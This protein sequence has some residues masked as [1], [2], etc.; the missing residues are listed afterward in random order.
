MKKTFLF[1]S[2]LTSI[3]LFS[4]NERPNILW[5][6]TE[7][8]SPDLSMYGD[9]LAK[10]PALDKLASESVIYDNVFSPVGVCAPTRSAIITGMYPTSIGTMHMRTGKDTGGWSKRVYDKNPKPQR[11]DINNNSVPQ[12]SAVIPAE[13]KCFTEYLRAIGYFCTNNSKTDYQFAA[14]ITSWD[15]NGGSAHWRNKQ[16]NQPFFSV[17]NFNVTH[18]SRLWMNAE[19]ELTVSPDSVKIPPYF[20]DTQTVRR[21]IARHYSNI[22]LMDKQVSGII[23]QLKEDGLY[24]N[25]IIFFYSDHGGP[26]PREKRAIYDSGLKVPMFIKDIDSKTIG[27]SDDLISFVDLAPT[28]LSLAN[29]EPPKYLDG[30]PFMGAFK[31]ELNEYVFGSSDRFD[32]FTDR[33]RSIRTKDF[34][35]VKNYF[36][37]KIKYKDVGYRKQI[38]MMVEFLESKEKGVLND[39]Q[40]IW[41][42]AKS[43]EE[44]Y[45]VKKDPYQMNNLIEDAEYQKQLKELR[46]VYD[47]HLKKHEDYG[48]TPELEMLYSMWPNLEQ[49]TTAM[50]KVKQDG[51]AVRISCETKG[52]SLAYIISDSLMENYDYDSKWQL[53]SEPLKSMNGKY[54]YI[55]A[56]RIGYKESEIVMHK[57]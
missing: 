21:D 51:K 24:D 32:E 23:E 7:D 35:Y 56:E 16:N 6:V 25:T 42:N 43:E 8:I 44:L 12:Y 18:E 26:L 39:A 57:L 9:A 20:Q 1:I 55:I 54:L 27:R 41:F 29:I 19:K 47:R 3:F 40:G 33:T 30:K 48:E 45:D 46:K 13:V 4:Q 15:E 49:P 34:L 31:K 2:V 22:E 53:Y 28:L 52:A 36:P 14:P 37:K 38:P 17:F 50:P 11:L 10:T 5:I